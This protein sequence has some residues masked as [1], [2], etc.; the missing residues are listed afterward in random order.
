MAI[1]GAGD[2]SPAALAALMARREAE[3]MECLHTGDYVASR[4]FSNRAEDMKPL[5][6]A[7]LDTLAR[8]VRQ[9]LPAPAPQVIRWS[10]VGDFTDWT[11]RGDGVAKLEDPEPDILG[12][13]RAV[14]RGY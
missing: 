8:A 3:A 4:S 13:I 10:E 9:P 7:D 1:Q 5:S 11:P 12:I 14:A 2:I 6:A